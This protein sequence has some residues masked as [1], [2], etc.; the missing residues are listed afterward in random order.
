MLSKEILILY[1]EWKLWSKCYG[2]IIFVNGVS[3]SGK[4]TLCRKLTKKG[5]YYISGDD[6][7]K[8]ILLSAIDK[9]PQFSIYKEILSS[10]D[11]YA[12]LYGTSRI[13]KHYSE[14]QLK[15]IKAIQI[16]KNLIEKTLSEEESDIFLRLYK[17][18]YKEAL[19]HILIG[20]HVVTDGVLLTKDQLK[21]TKSFF[22]L[23]MII[24]LLYTPLEQTL[25]HCFDRNTL[26]LQQESDDSRSPYYILRQFMQIYRF[27][28]NSNAGIK[29]NS[30]KICST[31]LKCLEN[32]D[33]TLLPPRE[34]NEI[35]RKEREV[36]N[37]A[38]EAFEI[39][40]TIYVNSE[41]SHDL[42]IQLDN[43]NIHDDFLR[44][45]ILSD[46][47]DLSSAEFDMIDLIGSKVSLDY[48]NKRLLF[49]S[50]DD[51][52]SSLNSQIYKNWSIWFRC[53]G[54]ILMI[55]GVTCSG[56][57]TLAKE[58][59]KYGYKYFKDDVT[60]QFI[61]QLIKQVI[62]SIPYEKLFSTD[63]ALAALFHDSPLNKEYSEDQ[64]RFID[65]LIINKNKII[66]LIEN[67]RGLYLE[68]TYT[69]TKK[70][71]SNGFNV[72][73]DI[74]HGCQTEINMFLNHF[75]TL[76]KR[77]LLYSPLDINIENCIF[78]NIKS[79]E[80]NKANF[81]L[82]SSVIK[83]FTQLFKLE[84][85]SNY[86][87]I[88]VQ[89]HQ[90]YESL[91][92]AK[93][94]FVYLH[95]I[96]PSFFSSIQDEHEKI[97]NVIKMFS[98]SNSCFVYVNYDYDLI[99]HLPDRNIDKALINFLLS[100]ANDC[101][102][103]IHFIYEI[104]G[105][106]LHL[107]DSLISDQ[108]FATDLKPTEGNMQGDA[109]VK[110]NCII[111]YANE[112]YYDNLLVNHQELL[113]EAYKRG[114]MQTVN[115]LVEIGEDQKL[116]KAMITLSHKYGVQYLINILFIKSFLTEPRLSLEVD[117]VE[118]IAEQVVEPI[119]FL[120]SMKGR[121]FIKTIANNF[122]ERTLLVI[123][124][125]G[126]DKD[127]AEQIMDEAEVQ[128]VGKVIYTLLGK[129]PLL[130]GA[131]DN[132]ENILSQDE[133]NQLKLIPN[134]ILNSWSNKAYQSIAYYIDNLAKSLD[135]M[136]NM[137]KSGTSVAITIALLEEWLGFAASGHR[138]VGGVP[139][140]YYDPNSD[141]DW[142]NGGGG[143]GSYYG[144]SNS[145]LENTNGFT[146]LILPLYNGT[147]YNIMTTQCNQI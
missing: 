138:F 132:L 145:S 43:Y 34:S 126:K 83:E 64:K 20:E 52:P 59:L 123:L 125:L 42:V 116:A 90:I 89:K 103:N 26:A 107:K 19:K 105:S 99:I 110:F 119:F 44:F 55:N 29:I 85:V 49:E 2:K 147:D 33:K 40:D 69:T 61:F 92:H 37:V 95:R 146:G 117:K 139:S 84:P 82:P 114:G 50:I 93:E 60:H 27:E 63:D 45:V 7:L 129:E 10:D 11:I 4:T 124:E 66:S 51:Y 121:D 144:G 143:S 101:D 108:V 18:T 70:Y 28:S 77:V 128:G 56:K 96:H 6:M 39:H 137:G 94:H 112:F 97:N 22:D 91:D 3:S 78:R 1:N 32:I 62:P 131:I 46:A 17:A 133:L 71:L 80:N 109:E 35:V 100:Y 79:L 111:C 140:S 135:G 24:L 102:I 67:T 120:N 65:L 72:V 73:I 15:A 127:I 113:I 14:M 21:I 13:N 141:D 115:K 36:I 48:R 136:L 81:R 5:F 31:L 118:K 12:S 76:I 23:P 54:K 122:D 8:G 30:Y 53:L 68:L 86:C 47:I 104:K 25:Q 74:R 142:L 57:T 134:G 16:S 130:T 75:E 87:K 38:Y 58:F 9:I 106:I 98:E 88:L 41:L